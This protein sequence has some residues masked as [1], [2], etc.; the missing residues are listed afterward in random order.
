[1]K[2]KPYGPGSGKYRS[3]GKPFRMCVGGVFPD[4][5]SNVALQGQPAEQFHAGRKQNPFP[6]RVS[7]SSANCFQKAFL[8]LSMVFYYFMLFLN[9][10]FKTKKI[11][12]TR[13]FCMVRLFASPCC[14]S[15]RECQAPQS[16][17]YTRLLTLAF[18]KPWEQSYKVCQ[19]YF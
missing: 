5:G 4:P 13:F 2:V 16:K 14:S 10:D 15:V 6:Y 18:F 1:M 12:P 9:L 7:H 19:S 3:S 17:A 8:S 11:N